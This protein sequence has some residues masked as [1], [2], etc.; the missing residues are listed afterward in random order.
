MFDLKMTRNASL[1]GQVA[2]KLREMTKEERKQYA[3]SEIELPLSPLLLEEM[4]KK[5]PPG[6]INVFTPLIEDYNYEPEQLNV[7]ELL[8]G[9]ITESNGQTEPEASAKD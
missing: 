1:L 3:E 2:M 9:T 5:V 4:P 7:E 8:N 6:T